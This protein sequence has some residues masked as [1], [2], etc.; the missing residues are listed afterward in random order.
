[1]NDHDLNA[2]LLV[3][4]TSVL[5]RKPGNT[6]PPSIINSSGENLIG[7]GKGYADLS[8]GAGVACLGY[9][10][11]Y[12]KEHMHKQLDT[13]PYLHAASFTCQPVEAAAKMILISSQAKKLNAID[14]QPFRR[15]AVA[16]FSG[17]AEAIEA[18]CKI[19]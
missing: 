4:E 1:M 13:L 12:V 3:V 9:D 11:R 15:G 19:A 10:D 18:A 5:H 16:F 7:R 6:C 14:E 2:D 8:A 17:G